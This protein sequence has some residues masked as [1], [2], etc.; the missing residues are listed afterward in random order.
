MQNGFSLSTQ[1]Q[2]L[3]FHHVVP[4]DT[5]SGI[6]NAYFPG[7]SKHIQ[8]HI[9]Q[10]LVDNPEVN[11]PDIIKPG[12]LIVLRTAVPNLCLP[13]IEPQET[14]RVKT[15]WKTM[16]KKTQDAIKE[17]S[18]IYNALTLGLAGGGTALFTLKNTLVSNMSVLN[19]IPDAYHDY[20]QGK[21]SKYEFDKIRKAKLNRY[22]NNIGPVINNAL[23][24]DQ[25]VK[26]SFKLKPGRSLNPTKTMTQHLN[27]LTSISKAASNGGVILA[28]VGLV[29]NCY[30]ISQTEAVTEKNEIAVKAI[31]STGIGALT[32]AAA[33][34]ILVGTPVGWGIILVI[35]VGT[36]IASYTVGEVAGGL[37]KLHFSDTDIVNSLGINKLCN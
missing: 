24:D 13:P 16:D 9:Q 8:M 15:L 26:N 30:Q 32:G 25:L 5:L 3:Y 17:T 11:N 12:Q 33:T 1:A 34:V 36:A 29:A 6:I 4:G 19:G 31:T 37:Y 14:Q 20:K 22:S 21:I 7:N 2:D 10:A 18:G 35:G 27:K 23:Y 28:G